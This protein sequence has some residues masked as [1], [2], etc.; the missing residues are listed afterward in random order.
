MTE[1][2]ITPEKVTK[3]IQLLAAWLVGLVAIDSAFLVAAQQIQRPDWASGLLVVA[4]VGNVPIFLTALFLLQTKFRPQMQEDVFYAK[5]LEGSYSSSVLLSSEAAVKSD[6][7]EA[8]RKLIQR[9]GVSVKGKEASIVESLNESL[10]E[11]LISRHAGS[12]ALA[13]L[14]LAPS[15]WHTVVSAFGGDSMFSQDIGGL[16][17]DGLIERSAEDFSDAMLT[18]LGVKVA[19][20]AEKRG[21]LI[22][23][24]HSDKWERMREDLT[25]GRV[26]KLKNGRKF[27][28]S[29]I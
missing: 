15:S 5:Y 27:I 16:L 25:S 9:L 2:K 23:Q 6:V 17:T 24:T 13:E 28:V 8:A 29:N 1:S 4:A 10:E 22:S 19:L 12:R 11:S 26:V 18:S 14:H 3:P 20:L 21:M 7:T